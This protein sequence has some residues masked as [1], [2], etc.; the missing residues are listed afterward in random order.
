MIIKLYTA[1]IT[2]NNNKLVNILAYVFPYS[3]GKR[4]FLEIVEI[5]SKQFYKTEI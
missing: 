5:L 2:M 4:M 3:G 1:L